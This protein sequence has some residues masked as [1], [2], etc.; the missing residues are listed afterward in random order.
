MVALS[1]ATTTVSSSSSS[2]LQTKLSNLSLTPSPLSLHTQ[3]LF[4]PL[5]LLKLN[6]THFP[7]PLSLL[8][9]HHFIPKFSAF[10][11]FEVDQDDKISARDDLQSEPEELG[12]EI[13]EEKEFVPVE[14]NDEGRLYVGNLPYSMTSSELTEVMQE[15]GSVANVEIIYDRVTD[16]SRGFGFVTMASVEEAKEAIKMFNE[17]MIASVKLFEK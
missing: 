9:T 11:S 14:S 8:S 3:Y 10:D 16:R 7:N 5:R 2:V 12:Q 4:K 13:E 15:A 17:S 6:N 1:V